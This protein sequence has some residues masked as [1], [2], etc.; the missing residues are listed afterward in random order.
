MKNMRLRH[1]ESLKGI[2]ERNGIID[3]EDTRMLIYWI[4][5]FTRELTKS[6]YPLE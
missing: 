3:D 6:G 1:I 4:D 2:Y 5:R